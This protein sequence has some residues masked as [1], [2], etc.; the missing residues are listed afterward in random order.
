MAV[1]R[2]AVA[3]IGEVDERTWQQALGVGWTLEESAELFVYL[4]ADVFTSYFNHYVGTDLDFP[5]APP[6]S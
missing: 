2:Q 5:S 1:A 6:L 3:H 4:A